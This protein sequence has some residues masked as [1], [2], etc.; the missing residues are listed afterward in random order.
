LSYGAITGRKR[1]KAGKKPLT[2]K[3]RMKKKKM[4]KQRRSKSL[5][6][7]FV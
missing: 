4:R 2:K 1:D 3:E 7:R 6:T 5:E